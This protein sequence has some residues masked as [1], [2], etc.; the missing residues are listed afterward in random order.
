[1]ATADL[2]CNPNESVKGC[3]GQHSSDEA[4]RNRVRKWHES[5]GDEGWDSVSNI[6]PVDRCDLTHHHASHLVLC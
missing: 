2:L 1:M 3:V 5:E 4:I 6:G